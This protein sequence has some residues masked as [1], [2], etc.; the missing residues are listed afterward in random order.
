MD[1]LLNIDEIRVATNWGGVTPSNY[2][3]GHIY[4]VT[5]GGSGCGAQSF[6]VGLSGSDTGVTYMLYTN[7]IFTGLTANGTGTSFNFVPNQSTSALYT[8]VGS[9]NTAVPSVASTW[10]KGSATVTVET[11]ASITSQPRR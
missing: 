1:P 11:T 9:N 8:V 10:M 7:G 5:G 4:N 6:P 3:G 2:W